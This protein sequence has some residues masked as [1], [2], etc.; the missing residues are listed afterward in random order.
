VAKIGDIMTYKYLSQ[1]I[2]SEL[3]VDGRQSV[4]ELAEKLEVSATTIAKRLE[5]LENDGILRGVTADIDYE[6]LGYAYL[7]ITRCKVRGDAFEEVL[8]LFKEL[9]PL[10]D[11]YEITGDY[12][13]LAIGHYQDRKEMNTIVKRLQEHDGIIETN[14]SIAL[15]ILR[16]NGQIPLP[17]GDQETE[18]S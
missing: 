18:D 8:E 2:L 14:T 1:K 10:T 3:Q 16:E 13:V 17:T 4:R 15:R 7:A 12:D 11:I 9:P 6:K 5:Q